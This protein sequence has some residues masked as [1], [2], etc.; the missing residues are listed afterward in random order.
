MIMCH[1][2]HATGNVLKD[3]ELEVPIKLYVL[4]RQAIFETALLSELVDDAWVALV[5]AGADKMQQVLV[6]HLR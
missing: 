4:I 6:V 2:L 5:D 3:A 1:A